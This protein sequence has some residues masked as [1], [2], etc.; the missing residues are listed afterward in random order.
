MSKKILG[1]ALS[2]ALMWSC[3]VISHAEEEITVPHENTSKITIP[4]ITEAGVF[5]N[6]DEGS[7]TG[8]TV[9]FVYESA[10]AQ[11]VQIDL[12]ANLYEPEQKVGVVPE[13]VYTPYEWQDGMILVGYEGYVLDLEKAENKDLWSVS[14]PLPHGMY[15]YNYLVDGEIADDPTNPLEKNP[16]N[17]NID[18]DCTVYVP[19][20]KEK[21]TD[22]VDFS[23]LDTA[24]VTEA[25][26]LLYVNYEDIYGEEAPLGI[27]LPYNYDPEREEPYKIVYISHGAAANELNWF[28]CGRLNTEFDHL[29]QEGKTEPA[30]LVTMNNSPY[31]WDFGIT[32]GNLMNYIIPYMESNY[33]V[34][35]DPSG[36]A[37]CGLSMGGMIA[38]NLLCYFPDSFDY[39]GMFSG[40]DGSLDYSDIQCE[41]EFPSVMM[42]SGYYDFSWSGDNVGT[43][44]DRFT[45]VS[46]ALKMGANNIPYSL[47]LVEGG[48]DWHTWVQLMYLFATEYLWK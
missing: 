46:T 2:F 17:G 13:N 27:Y 45:A 44:K 5:V 8:Y 24:T 43:S 38:S 16:N 3:S 21:Q 39:L 20:N 10:D 7:A 28:G 30:V 19:L 14:I 32:I 15:Q 47:E 31:D 26:E 34:S 4:E 9:T 36:R 41:G 22:Y 35:S 37:F 40:T 1:F 42:A 12:G 23:Y 6:E 25:G 18:N 11:T 29:I 33:N 48:H